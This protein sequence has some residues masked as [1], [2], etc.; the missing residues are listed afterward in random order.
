MQERPPRTPGTGDVRERIPLPLV[1]VAVKGVHAGLPCGARCIGRVVHCDL[2]RAHWA[3][4]VPE[5]RKSEAHRTLA[6]HTGLEWPRVRCGQEYR[7][8]SSAGTAATAEVQV[9]ARH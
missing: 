6:V 8:D 5:V 1:G 4:A 3:E 2:M 7:I 9:A